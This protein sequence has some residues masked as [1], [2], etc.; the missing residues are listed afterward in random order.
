MLQV[1]TF[2]VPQQQEAANEF[3]KTH[4]PDGQINFNKD[5]IVIFWETGENPVEY[6]VAELRELIV[7]NRKARFQQE[8]ALHVLKAQLADLNFTKNKEQWQ[9][10]SRAIRN[11]EDAIANQ[12]LKAAFAEDK[13]KQL[14]AK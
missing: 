4:K 10:V 11:V 7:D 13:I 1:Q 3:L 9:D 6:Q 2:L 12:D 5:T 14:L 8:V